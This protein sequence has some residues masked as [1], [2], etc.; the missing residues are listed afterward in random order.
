[1]PVY[2]SSRLSNVAFLPPPSPPPHPAY[3]RHPW[4]KEGHMYTYKYTY[5]MTDSTTAPQ[6]NP[7]IFFHGRFIIN[8][9][10]SIQGRILL[11]PKHPYIFLCAK[12]CRSMTSGCRGTT[13][14]RRYDR[15]LV[16]K[17]AISLKKSWEGYRSKTHICYIFDTCYD[18]GIP[19]FGKNGV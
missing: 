3:K 18:R 11:K 13:Y 7:A 17:P 4:E 6:K 1:M 12:V 5:I 14:C 10:C 16:L 9:G 2:T 19:F 8:H 15:E